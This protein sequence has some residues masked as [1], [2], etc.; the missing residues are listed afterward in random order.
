MQTVSRKGWQK[1]W[2]PNLVRDIW[3]RIADISIHLSHDADMLIAVKQRVFFVS[4][5]PHTT[6]RRVRSL[7]RLETG[8]GKHDNEPLCGLVRRCYRGVLLCYQLR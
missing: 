7:V 2:R 8:I 6:A 5:R 4:R 3:S 1:G